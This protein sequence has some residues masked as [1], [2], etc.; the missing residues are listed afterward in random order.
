MRM[1]INSFYDFNVTVIGKFISLLQRGG[2]QKKI[3]NLR[4][5]RYLAII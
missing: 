3:L 1:I 2:W 5:E 4:D